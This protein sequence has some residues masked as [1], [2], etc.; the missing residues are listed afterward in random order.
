MMYQQ[1]AGYYDALVKD[2]QATQDWCEFVKAHLPLGS[3]LEAA[4][5]SG[6]ITMA[7]AQAGYEVTAGDISE[8][9]MAQAQAKKGSENITWKPFD[10]RDLSQFST[11]DGI[12]CFCDSINY[13][14]KKVDV[15]QFFQQAY[16]HLHPSGT[17]LFDMHSLDRLTEFDEEYCE[18]GMLENTPYEWSITREDDYIYQNFAFYDRDA[19][20][21]LEQHIQ[22]VYDPMW[23]KQT[24][25][26]IGFQVHIFTDFTLPG[27]QPGEKYFY[28]CKKEKSA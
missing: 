4:C 13:L 2:D 12:L 7:L 16:L 18:D 5:G 22:R 1:L 8:A 10:M 19:R 21:H 14:L 24:L 20:V 11:F 9:M 3:I 28:V 27:I 25:E 17:L 6:E 23:V 15:A 26:Q